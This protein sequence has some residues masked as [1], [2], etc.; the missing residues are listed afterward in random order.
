MISCLLQR[1][2]YFTRSSLLEAVTEDK[3]ESLEG[4]L[5]DRPDSLNSTYKVSRFKGT[6]NECFKCFYRMGPAYCTWQLA[7]VAKGVC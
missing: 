4:L 1:P 2:C 7:M 6:V 5:H 3:K